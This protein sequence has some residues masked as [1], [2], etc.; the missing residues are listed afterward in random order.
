MGDDRDKTPGLGSAYALQT[1]DDSRRLY[2]AWAETYETGFARDMGYVL[3][4]A[5]AGAYA[6]LGGAG[7]V[8][9]LGAG[10]GL[11]GAALAERGVV[12]VDGTDIS[13]EM[14]AKA[15]EK[16]VYRRLFEGDLTQ[17]LPLGD[18]AYA[19]AVSAGTFTNGH[20]G[21]GALGEVLRVVA[22]GGWV[23][24]SVN[25]IHWQ[26]QGF[27]TALDHLAPRISGSRRAEAA[28]YAGATGPHAEDRAVILSLRVA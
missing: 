13:G 10:T 6:D 7:P 25:A 12:P 24:I 9:D 18:G 3:H 23:V 22:P 5:V 2:A 17:R 14:L 4:R 28:I 27:D 1:P 15:A 11:V 26:A 20:V 19:G 8:L 16:G 21:P